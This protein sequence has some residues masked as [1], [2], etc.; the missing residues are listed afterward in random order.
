MCAEST[1]YFGLK[2]AALPPGPSQRLAIASL[3]AARATS[4]C[5][6]LCLLKQYSALDVA[7]SQINGVNSSLTQSLK[8]LAAQSEAIAKR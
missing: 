8:A 7:V 3:C 6:A 4:D 1:G 5:P 2:A